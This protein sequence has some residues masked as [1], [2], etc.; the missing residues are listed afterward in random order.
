MTTIYLPLEM[1]RKDS[2]EA[3]RLLIYT[4][5]QINQRHIPLNKRH[6]DKLGYLVRQFN[7]GVMDI[8][9]FQ[10]GL[11]FVIKESIRMAKA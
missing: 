2:I 6:E 11:A 1:E 5:E 8:A 3:K 7:D 9:D 10:E 4:I